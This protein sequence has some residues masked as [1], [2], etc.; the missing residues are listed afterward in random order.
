MVAH[1]NTLGEE[2]SIK[3]HLYGTAKRAEEFA[4]EFGCGAAGNFC[5]I[6][7][8]IGK[9]SKQ[10]QERIRNPENTKKVD[11]STAGA[12]EALHI[13]NYNIP[14][15]MVIA[16]H[17]SGLMDG[18]SY[19]FSGEETGTFFGR[20]KS[21]IP[22][23]SGWEKD[24]KVGP[25]EVPPFCIKGDNRM[26]SMAFFIRMM[27]SCL[28]DADYLDTE[29]FMN[30]GQ[31]GRQGYPSI[32]DLLLRFEQYIGKWLGR[33]EFENEKQ[34]RL[35]KKRNQILEE[36]MEKG[37]KWDRGLYTLTVP[38][39]G[40]K[41]T[42]SLGFALKH[43]KK[44]GMK[45]V[46]YV[47]PYT[48]VIDQ[49]AAVFG[50]IL[51]EENILEHHSGM[52]YEMEENQRDHSLSCRKALA[53]ENWDMPIIVT[54]AVQFFESVFA[55]KSSKCRKL[56]NIANSVIIFDEAQTLPVSYLEPC[57]AAISELVAHYRST[58]IL[59][60]ATQPVLDSIFKKYLPGGE[61]QEICNDVMDLG[62]YFKR[63]EISNA[64]TLSLDE[65]RYR[66]EGREQVLCIVNKRKTAQELYSGLPKDGAFC[67]TTLLYPAHR[68][69]KFG[70]I[71]DRLN[72]GLPC[73]VIATSLVEAGVDLDFPEVYRQEIGLD[74]LIQ[75]AGRCN[76]EGRREVKESNVYLFRLEDDDNMFFGQNIDA[77][78]ETLRHYS[79]PA[80]LEAISFYFQFYRKL[81]GKENLD[82]KRIMDAFERGIGGSMF[83]FNTVSKRFKL[84]ESQTKTIYIPVDEAEEW[85]EELYNGYPTRKLFRKLGQYGVNAYP[86]HLRE[87]WEA[88]CLEMVG[89][90]VYVLRDMNQYSDDTGLQMDTET[91][92][93][94]F[95]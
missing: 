82:Q 60:T 72:R 83:P 39:G 92:F 4:E 55:S 47:I 23:Y 22:D 61:I 6:L 62:K 70:E 1:I 64:G 86:N 16:G 68:K 43:M 29:L 38:T 53:A 8:D 42:A 91:G 17:H 67:L 49:N 11:R 51:G 3:D 48:S 90:M 18:G 71:K 31:I 84:I 75:S 2:Q 66:I 36:C 81:L 32:E 94:F 63:T 89:D 45:R 76:R 15:S 52:L 93:G 28:V 95:V 30:G 74:S 73:R 54:T 41:T 21:K 34:K 37:E 85:I 77:L 25:A 13:S 59:C 78:R 58:V 35:Y 26:F 5:G 24:I 57:V 65:L 50:N 79:N 19:R 7:H 44:R 56:H 40:G 12:L 10:F 46:I 33:E 27:Y 14:F 80:S 69:K 88:G 87:L 9:Y 20:L